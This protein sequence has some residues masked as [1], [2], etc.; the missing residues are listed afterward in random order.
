[1]PYRLI[2]PDETLDFACDWSAFLA[3]SGSPGD[4]IATSTWSIVPAGPGLANDSRSGAV[5]TVFVSAA[6][7]GQVYR[8]T[9]RVTTALGRTAER[10]WILRCE[11][12]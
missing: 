5:T 2:D 10:S 9:N 4:D 12:R 1:M 11:N 3:D 6:Q 8:L 7:M